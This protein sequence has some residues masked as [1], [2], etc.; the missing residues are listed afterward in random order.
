MVGTVLSSVDSRIEKS[1]HRTLPICIQYNTVNVKERKRKQNN[2]RSEIQWNGCG[3]N[4]TCYCNNNTIVC[5]LYWSLPFLSFPYLHTHVPHSYMRGCTRTVRCT[6]L[7]RIS[8]LTYGSKQTSRNNAHLIYLCYHRTRTTYTQCPLQYTTL[9]SY[10]SRLV[11]WIEIT[12]WVARCGIYV[13][14]IPSSYSHDS[15]SGLSSL[16]VYL[17]AHPYLWYPWES[18]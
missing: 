15:P 12:M 7:N 3:R 16:S 9:P 14:P 17:C 8:L 2:S 13:R 11:L 4:N 5:C 10:D 1:E 6:N 18:L